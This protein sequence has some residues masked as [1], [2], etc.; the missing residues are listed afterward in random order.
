MAITSKLTLAQAMLMG[1]PLFIELWDESGV[2]VYRIDIHD[3]RT[4][5]RWGGVAT[6]HIPELA[7]DV[8]FTVAAIVM[9]A[10]RDGRYVAVMHIKHHGDAKLSAG[11]NFHLSPFDITTE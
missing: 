8:D 2:P 10:V 6:L 7:S 1:Y 4:E 9:T 11:S 3:C 5:I